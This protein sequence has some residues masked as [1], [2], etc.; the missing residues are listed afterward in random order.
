MSTAPGYDDPQELQLWLE[1]LLQ[2]LP[3]ELLT[4]LLPDLKAKADMSFLTSLPLHFGQL[5]AED[6]LNTSSSKSSPQPE[7]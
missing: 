2:P 4:K 3:D 7:Q 6:W 5:M 1:Q